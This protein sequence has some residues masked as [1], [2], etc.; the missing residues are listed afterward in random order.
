MHE[1]TS[2]TRLVSYGA[3]LASHLFFGRPH[4]AESEEYQAFRYKLLVLLMVSGAVFTGLF[5]LGNA[6]EVNPIQ[7]M[8]RWSMSVF[9]AA[10]LGL[11]TWLR[12]RPQRFWRAAWTYEAM[13]LLEYTSALVFVP[14]DELRILWYFVNVPCVFIMLGQR[15]GWWITLGTGVGF[16][17]GNAHLQAPYS[18]NALATAVLSLLYLGI[19]FHAYVDRSLSYFKRMRAY[20]QELQQLASRDPLTGLLNAR[21]YYA[22]CDQQI[23]L[24]QRQQRPFA[25]L[26]VD[27][28][29]FKRINDTLGHAAGDE[30]LRTVART[31]KDAVRSSDLLGR[32]GGEEFSILLPDTDAASALRLA[33]G[34]RRAVEAC[35][36]PTE[37]A[38]LTVTA[39]VGVAVSHDATTTMKHLQEQADE[40]MYQAKQAGRNRVSLLESTP[41]R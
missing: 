36:P 12:S 41:P 37:G 30:V 29:H 25:V 22:A 17:W 14:F 2:H 18:S 19:V 34:L 16:V 26:F 23:R 38:P 10:A 20:N 31:L 32:I 27:L 1:L 39:S 3:T 4:F 40:A 28:D 13:C 15:A 35:R 6:T 33:E 8:H 7:G 5:I 24:G 21:A 11:W 9:T